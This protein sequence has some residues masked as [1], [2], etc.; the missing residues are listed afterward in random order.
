MNRALVFVAR[1]TSV[2]A[3]A[4]SAIAADDA[5]GILR[6]SA[7]AYARLKTYRD[8]GVVSSRPDH[9]D[10]AFETD[11]E[12]PERFRYAFKD[13][14][15]FLPIRFLTIEHIV[16]DDGQ[17]VTTWTSSS[18]RDP[19]ETVDSSLASAVAGATGVSRASAHHIATLL[20]PHLWDHESFG[21]SVLALSQPTLMADDQIDGV[22]CRHVSA[23]TSKGVSIDVWIARSDHLVRR[24]DT[25]C[26]QGFAESEFH[27]NVRVD[28][29]IPAV[30]F[31]TRTEPH[32]SR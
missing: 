27:R 6:E 32:A 8:S 20:M 19:V 23:V 16:R 10:L 1:L 15:P 31:D 12:R 2:S 11:F 22:P 25:R 7:E 5:G 18:G 17:R 4:T 9:G 30:V 29:V 13:G 21:S 14:H 3:L 28:P 26:P 24:I